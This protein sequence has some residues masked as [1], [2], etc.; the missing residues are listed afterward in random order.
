M[1]I[2]A[3]QLFDFFGISKDIYL[4]GYF[5]LHQC[6]EELRGNYDAVVLSEVLEHLADP[7][8]ARHSASLLD[9]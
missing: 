6:P 7:A 5:P 1:R 3:R 8:K 9:R 4:G 2:K